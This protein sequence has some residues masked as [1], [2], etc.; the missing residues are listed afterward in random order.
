MAILYKEKPCFLLVVECS[1]RQEAVSS[2]GKPSWRTFILTYPV[3]I[4]YRMPST[5]SEVSAMLVDLHHTQQGVTNQH[6]AGLA[7]AWE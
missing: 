1:N 4:T 3:S 7:H 2:G 5:V 6:K